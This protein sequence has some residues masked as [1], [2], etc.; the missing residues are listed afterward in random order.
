[1]TN[2]SENVRRENAT[3]P[4]EKK[5]LEQRICH[6][7]QGLAKLKEIMVERGKGQ[8]SCEGFGISMH[9]CN[10]ARTPHNGTHIT[11]QEASRTA[12]HF[13]L[14]PISTPKQSHENLLRQLYVLCA[15]DQPQPLER[16]KYLVKMF[17]CYLSRKDLTTMKP[18]GWMCNMVFLLAPKVFMADEIG[19]CGYV[20]RYM[21]S[22][23]LVVNAVIVEL[24]SFENG[25]QKRWTSR[26]VRD[27]LLDATTIDQSLHLPYFRIIGFVMSLIRKRKKM[28]VL[29]SMGYKSTPDSMQLDNAMKS[30]F[31]EMLHIIKPKAHTTSSDLVMEYVDLRR[32][33]N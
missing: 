13:D 32:Q 8:P 14:G 3:L 23:K 20:T 16:D 10:D 5:K 12:S 19:S 21:F 15:Y 7:E 24:D 2:D 25:L 9:P 22:C 18:R 33:R 31:G 17:K 26:T 27:L 4:K 1:M 6:L 30:R 29:D 11:V 28:F